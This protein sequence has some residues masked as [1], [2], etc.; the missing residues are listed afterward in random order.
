MFLSN[1]RIALGVVVYK[2]IDLLKI[3][4]EC[5][6]HC[7]QFKAQMYVIHNRDVAVVSDKGT[8]KEEAEPNE[9]S[10]RELCYQ[11]DQKKNVTYIPRKNVGMD[12]GAFQDV[13]RRRLIDVASWDYL[14]WSTDDTIPVR[15][16]FIIYFLNQIM[17]RPH[18]GV[19]G[20]E[21]SSLHSEH[22]RTNCFAISRKTATQVMFPVET[23]KTKEDCYQFEHKG[24]TLALQCKRHGLKVVDIHKQHDYVMWDTGHHPDPERFTNTLKQAE[25]GK[26]FDEQRTEA[27]K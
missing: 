10:F 19:A 12:I 4:L 21:L 7:N 18:V 6:K 5:W 9:A 20:V 2:R 17:N 27:D 16:D 15:K 22:V 14:V 8:V 26:P 23:V 1:P 25:E 13:C 3:W 11:Y 24:N